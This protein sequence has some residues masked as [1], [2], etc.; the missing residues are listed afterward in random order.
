MEA[1]LRTR[2]GADVVAAVCR[3]GMTCV[4]AYAYNSSKKGRHA[5]H[6]AGFR[7]EI[8]TV[9]YRST[10]ICTNILRTSARCQSSSL[11]LEACTGALMHQ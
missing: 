4:Y 11:N 1:C 5:K 3:S 7:Y 9:V 2:L 8:F 6:R 10:A